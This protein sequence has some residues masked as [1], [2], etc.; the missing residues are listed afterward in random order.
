[1]WLSEADWPFYDFNP[2][3]DEDDPEVLK[4]VTVNATSTNQDESLVDRLSDR[5]SCWFRLKRVLV[6]MIKF[7]IACNKERQFFPKV[8]IQQISDGRL[9]NSDDL[10]YV[11]I[12]AF[13]F[14][15]TTL[16]STASL[17]FAQKLS[18]K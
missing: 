18:T 13:F 16:I 1:M 2:K 5:I 12:H 17:R 7:L 10:M 3:V 14:I 6:T 11:E 4:T 15:S 8:P 9:V